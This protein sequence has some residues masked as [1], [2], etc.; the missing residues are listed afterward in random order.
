MKQQIS[1]GG[2]KDAIVIGSGIAGLVTARV[3][4]DFYARVTIFERDHLPEGIENRNGVPQDRH[5]HHLLKR[6]QVILEQLFP[7]LMAQLRMDG[8]LLST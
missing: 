3:L 2:R 8:P 1:P 4:S 5:P 6:G 7:G